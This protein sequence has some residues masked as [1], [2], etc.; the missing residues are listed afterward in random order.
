MKVIRSSSII[1]LKV[2]MNTNKSNN[3]L[4]LLRICLIE[5]QTMDQALLHETRFWATW[6][7][8]VLSGVNILTYL[9]GKS[10]AI[11]IVVKI[12]GDLRDFLH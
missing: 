7:K 4:F 2:L 5:L 1:R 8:Q 12:K 6:S 11:V 3:D 10:Y 9:W